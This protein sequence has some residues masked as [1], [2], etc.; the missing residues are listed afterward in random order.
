MLSGNLSLFRSE[1]PPPDFFDGPRGVL[2]RRWADGRA[3]WPALAA[4]LA[5]LAIAAW[6]LTRSPLF[7]ADRIRVVG[8]A[9]LARAD[10]LETAAVDGETNVLL[11]DGSSVE[12][13]LERNPWIASAAV[14]RSLPSTIHISI[15][16]RTPV[17]KVEAARGWALIATDGT[18]VARVRKAP[19]YPQIVPT[20]ARVGE[21][22][23]VLLA[24]A[25]VVAAMSNRLR[26]KVAAV[27][28]EPDGTVSLRLAS[29]TPVTFG[30]PT[31]VR[32]KSQALAAILTW[33]W[34]N[35]KDL[36]A[37]DVTAPFAPTARLY[38]P[39]TLVGSG[40]AT[41]LT[42][43]APEASSGVRLHRPHESARR[44]PA[45][46]KQ[47]ERLRKDDRERGGKKTRRAG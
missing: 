7:H 17:A 12:E 19:G 33:A 1:A 32:A 4:G 13:R 34:R 9:H 5:L 25:A 26:S 44:Q 21:R 15:R 24:L 39:T 38:R 23:R 11:L 47:G 42:A 8:T 43:L 3:R 18:P 2:R 10:V 45:V 36:V 20:A 35:G 30:K 46:R 37:I 28:A 16:E 14:G 40:D 31:S 29:G 22:R 27:V 6:S 41:G